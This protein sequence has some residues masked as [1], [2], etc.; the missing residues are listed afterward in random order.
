MH[1]GGM[2]TALFNYLV[3]KKNNGDFILR[4]E[5]T[6]QTRF[7]EGAEQYIIESLRWCGIEFNEGVNIGGP[8]APYR[9][10]E[11]KEIYKKYAEQLVHSGHAY[12]A[13]DTP[14]E[15]ENLRKEF[16]ANKKTFTYN[17]AVRKSL[18]NSLV[19]PESETRKRIESGE[20]YVIRFKIPENEEVC[21]NDIIRGS[22]VVQTNTLDDK[23]LY[24]SDGMPTYHLAN[25]V[26]DYLMKISHVI[27]GEEWL[28]STPLHVLLYRAF[29]WENEMPEFAHLPLILKPD[30]KGK[31]SK[32]DGDR[33]GFPVFPLQ[34]LNPETKEIT[35]GYRESGYFP[36]AFINIIALL[37]W[38]SGT[39][40][41]I[42]NMNDLI[43]IFSLDRIIKSGAKFDPDKAKWFNHQYLIQKSD[44]EL[45]QLFQI[46]LKEKNINVPDS[47]VVKIVSMIKERANFVK[48]FWDESSFFFVAPVEFDEK[49]VAKNW[50]ENTQDLL[51]EAKNILSQSNP[52]SAEII[53][54]NFKIFIDKQGIGFGQM[55]VPLRIALVGSSK[56]PD[57]VQII[58]MLGKEEVIK[59]IK[60]ALNKIK[61]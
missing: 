8:Y 22:M 45:A 61:V 57:L 25:V 5:D 50:K 19:L 51:S 39:E 36:D 9:Q 52:F 41:E 38:N 53:H 60:Y 55:M 6:D 11:R 15:I 18:K 34:W 2:R 43:K 46:I 20:H 24:K 17:S 40:Q 31:L 33:L 59:R 10:S 4:I 3:A 32:R 12:Y 54:E 58:E 26:D 35:S 1:I 37:G 16:E 42:F 21:F 13:F 44:E 27:R 49:A 48:D 29:G 7:M 14:E 47:F 23:V 28:P 30:G 56:G